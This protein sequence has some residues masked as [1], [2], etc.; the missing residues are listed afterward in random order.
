MVNRVCSRCS[1]QFS[2][3]RGHRHSQ[4]LLAV[5]PTTVATGLDFIR[6]NLIVDGSQHIAVGIAN[7]S[8]S[9][10]GWRQL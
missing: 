5:R 3:R 7:H 8:G 9:P 2:G 1:S 10:P 6:Q 4:G